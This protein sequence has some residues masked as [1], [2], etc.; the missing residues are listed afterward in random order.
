MDNRIQMATFQIITKIKMSQKGIIMG[1][2]KQV[3]EI[4]MALMDKSYLR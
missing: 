2:D 3:S 1:L 4:L